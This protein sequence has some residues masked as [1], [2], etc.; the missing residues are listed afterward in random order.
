MYIKLTDIGK[1]YDYKWIIRNLTGDI[2]SGSR[3]SIKGH[4]G[5]GKSTLVKLLGGYLSQTCGAI[6]YW[7]Q[8]K[9]ISREHIFRHLTISAPY[10]DLIEEFTVLEMVQFH[11]KLKH[12]SK[13]E[14]IIKFAYLEESAHTPVQFLSSGMLQ[15]LKLA[16]CFRTDADL[17]L[18]DE[19][20]SNL[21][22]AGISWYR[23]ALHEL[24]QKATVVVASNVEHDFPE[25]S[26]TWD[27]PRR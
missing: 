22:A 25:N 13:P 17:F 6:E 9:L 24:P 26:I 7:N 21:D 11:S 10:I 20:T 15:R 1:Q 16:L 27:M 8:E 19:P 2:P 23:H 14:E 18:F 4:N 12:I 5:S 3:L